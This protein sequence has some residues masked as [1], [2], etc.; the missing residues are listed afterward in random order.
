MQR[1]ENFDSSLFHYINKVSVNVFEHLGRLLSKNNLSIGAQEWTLLSHVIEHPGK[2]QKWYGENILKDKTTTMRLVDALEKKRL[3]ERKADGTDRRHNLLYATADGKRLIAGT[4][5]L[6]GD[7]FRWVF[8]GIE[9]K[10]L[11]TTISVL[12]KVIDNIASH[13]K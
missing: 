8:A 3:V 9:K 13:T 5:P 1:L 12:R 4:L 10:H 2:S 7:T 6:I 11:A